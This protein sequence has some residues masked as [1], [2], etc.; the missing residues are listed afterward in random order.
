MAGLN[1][2][3]RSGASAKATDSSPEVRSGATTASLALWLA[4]TAILLL[5]LAARIYN[6]NWD[7]GTHAHPDERHMTT[8]TLDIK[9][10]GSVGQYFDT[11]TSPL[12]PYNLESKPS[13]VYGT[14]P[15]FLTKATAELFGK[16]NYDDLVLVGRQ[17]T[18][19]FSA[20]TI[21]FAFLA[22]RRLY[23]PAAGLIAAG[24]L[25]A[26]PLAIQHAH[27]Y[28]TDT[29]LT[30]FIAAAFYFA[31]RVMQEGRPSDYALTGL[32]LGLGMACK[33]T[34]VLFVPVLL[35][36]AAVRLWPLLRARLTWNERL[37]R[38]LLGVVLALLVAFI[39]F[40]VFQPYAFDGV[41]SLNQHWVDDQK[42]QADLLGGNVGFPPSVQW[43]D[44]TSYLYPLQQMV[45]W[46]MG[47]AF[48]IAGWLALLTPPTGCS[49]AAR[50]CTCCP[51]VFV[52]AYF[53]FMGR[54]FSLYLRYFLPLYP[55]LAVTA[56]F[57]LVELYRG[58]GA[59]AGR[60]QRPWI[61]RAGAGRRRRRAPRRRRCRARL[62]GHLQPRLH[63]RRRHPLAVPKRP[64]RRRYRRRV[65]GRNPA[66]GHPEPAG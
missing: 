17:L 40:R 63:A 58:A 49:A 33:I 27:F 10:P 65:L 26:A 24:L 61:E 38:P 55:V 36:A 52:L 13:F 64:G 18:A 48:G 31:V 9:L 56:G 19:L 34:G 43:I 32:M 51:L 30:F 25:A 41:I 53:G 45:F 37:L 21:L 6:V 59:L 5:G 57:G 66:D 23:G 54:Q 22:A 60:L 46:G 2:R 44:R 4:V 16:D 28:V 11:A 15:V 20:A 50:L 1:L 12:N 3:W 29:Y 8:V 42:S 7:E 14:F 35:A 62:H 47:P 39:A